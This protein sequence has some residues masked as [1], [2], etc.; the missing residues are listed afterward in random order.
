MSSDLDE[1][2]DVVPQMS[3]T[4]SMP[5]IA[6]RVSFSLPEDEEDEAAATEEFTSEDDGMKTPELA[7]QAALSPSTTTTT[8]T[9]QLNSATNNVSSSSSRFVPSKN[10]A[11]KL[12]RT[13]SPPRRPKPSMN[14]TN[15]ADTNIN[16]TTIDRQLIFSPGGTVTERRFR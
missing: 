11:H 16:R 12:A 4:K 9:N 13:P 5:S 2:G 7:I 8:T 3:R 15:N 14:V 1:F 10:S 6:R